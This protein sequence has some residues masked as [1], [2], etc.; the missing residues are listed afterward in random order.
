MDIGSKQVLQLTTTKRGL[1]SAQ[2]PVRKYRGCLLLRRKKKRF[3]VVF[4]L[5][6]K[7]GCAPSEEKSNK[8]SG[9]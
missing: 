1:H 2:E 9:Y 3:N 7:H 6:M 8:L 5:V 4:E